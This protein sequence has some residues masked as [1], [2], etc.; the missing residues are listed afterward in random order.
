MRAPVPVLRCVPDA[1]RIAALLAR[2]LG[3]AVPGGRSVDP[4]PASAPAAT[5]AAGAAP[6]PVRDT[7]PAF[8]H[9]AAA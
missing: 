2:A 3:E 6:A 8:A 4:A 5:P 9:A 7:V 1:D